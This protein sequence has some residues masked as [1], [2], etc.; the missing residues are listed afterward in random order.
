MRLVHLSFYWRSVLEG[1]DDQRTRPSVMTPNHGADG[2]R[3]TQKCT[4]V[5]LSDIFGVRKKNSTVR[6]SGRSTD[7]GTSDTYVSIL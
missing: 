2:D 5:S 3:V 6:T 7:N 4:P 1:D